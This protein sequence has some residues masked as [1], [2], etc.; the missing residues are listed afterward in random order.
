VAETYR[1]KDTEGNTTAIVVEGRR[2]VLHRLDLASDLDLAERYYCA[3]QKDPVQAVADA[4][5]ALDRN[6][7]L[8]NDIVSRLFES[9]RA[10]GPLAKPSR[11]AIKEWLDT[12]AGLSFSLH[13]QLSRNHPDEFPDPRRPGFDLAKLDLS[14]AR[15]FI[16]VVSE[17]EYARLRD[18]SVNAVPKNGEAPTTKE[19][20][21]T[22]TAQ[23][24]QAQIGSG[25]GTI[26]SQPM[27][28]LS[29]P[30]PIEQR[31]S[32][33]SARPGG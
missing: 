32:F 28:Q 8:K 4:A 18:R 16:N 33:K 30:V 2:Y 26:A 11:Q 25:V 17:A 7:G 27:K 6:P 1:E 15:H 5:E 21:E 31:Q 24:V 23:P 9:L 22:E 14:R 10:Q 19:N 20:E 3:C 13:C 12:T 29:P